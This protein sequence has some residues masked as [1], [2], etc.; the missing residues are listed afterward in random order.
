M[1]HEPHLSV[2]CCDK[3]H[4]DL[5]P[6]WAAL[7]DKW[8]RSQPIDDWENPPPDLVSGYRPEMQRC[9]C[10]EHL[11][12]DETGDPTP[13]DPT[14]AW[15]YD[16]GRPEL[17]A[18]ARGVIWHDRP[19]LT[20]GHELSASQSDALR[21]LGCVL[22]G[23]RFWSARIETIGCSRQATKWLAELIA[24]RLRSN[25]CPCETTPVE[26]R[27]HC[28]GLDG[29]DGI[30]CFDGA[31]F[32]A[33]C[34][35]ENPLTPCG[36]VL[37]VTFAV[38]HEGTVP[39]GRVDTAPE[40][41][42]D[43]EVC[44]PGCPP[45]T[46]TRTVERLV[47]RPQC[48]VSVVVGGETRE[49]CPVDIALS[50]ID[51]TECYVAVSSVA[52]ADSDCCPALYDLDLRTMTAVPL[53]PST[54]PADP[55]SSACPPEVRYVLVDNVHYDPDCSACYV[56]AAPCLDLVPGLQI[57]SDGYVIDPQAD[58]GAGPRLQDAYPNYYQYGLCLG[59]FDATQDPRVNG[60]GVGQWFEPNDADP[61]NDS[62]QTLPNTPSSG[63]PLIALTKGDI[64][65]VCD[66]VSRVA[67]AGGGPCYE[68]TINS[69]LSV[70]LSDPIDPAV[71]DI[72]SLSWVTDCGGG[73]CAGPVPSP[74]PISVSGG[75][76]GPVGWIVPDGF[77]PDAADLLI[78]EWEGSP[79]SNDPV[80][81]LVDE[82]IPIGTS[83]ESPCP[84]APLPVAVAPTPKWPACDDDERR[85][86]VYKLDVPT[87]GTYAPTFTIQTAADVPYVYAQI[88][89]GPASMPVPVAANWQQYA[90]EPRHT[91]LRIQRT[92]PGHIV[93]LD[94]DGPYV[95]CDGARQNAPEW[96]DFI[97]RPYRKSRICD[98]C[99]YLVV[100][101]PCLSPDPVVTFGLELLA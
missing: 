34:V 58:P 46:Q 15:W 65:T 5:S 57:D 20:G 48:N 63:N 70:S 42:Y 38:R 53:H 62:P 11:V 13:I 75:E 49:V 21:S 8:A 22:P 76:W 31:E 87:G 27:C 9:V 84:P 2:G 45:T 68:V 30:R 99:A 92:G 18:A 61:T 54:W 90:C 80:V 78:V 59:V 25:N 50:D 51:A 83:C 72:P 33:E 95:C 3:S 23:L 6:W 41:V 66:P 14:Q 17:S 82:T 52:V 86:V 88:V 44:V 73:V 37:D 60:V 71:D 69:D 39:S 1:K 19:T 10:P 26:V 24:E 47:A 36:T 55:C 85:I 32:F 43:E 56:N 96:F 91:Q 7:L 79:N 67:P 74:A 100:S 101:L 97:G 81:E 35:D 12:S 94:K 29:D 77:E 40:L 98:E 28:G 93:G 4:V 89:S 16:P 64:P